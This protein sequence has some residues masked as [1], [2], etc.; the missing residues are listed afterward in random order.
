MPL[1]EF[2]KSTNIVPFDGAVLVM[3]MLF[4]YPTK[5]SMILGAMACVAGLGICFWAKRF[6]FSS[7]NFS[8][9]GPYLFVRY[10]YLLGH[11]VFVFGCII[12][13]RSFYFLVFCVV[14]LGYAYAR[15]INYSEKSAYDSV[16]ADYI[17]YKS[18]VPAFIPQLVPFHQKNSPKGKDSIVEKNGFFAILTNDHYTELIRSFGAS[19]LLISGLVLQQFPQATVTKYIGAVLLV[20]IYLYR[21]LLEYRL[22]VPQSIKRSTQGGK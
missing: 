14:L 17:H 8:A 18:S 11:F 4:A 15:I 16:D 13:A 6:K 1:F 12:M 21:Y 3:A 10:P 20:G 2:K 7:K 22:R 19:V 9:N 5:T